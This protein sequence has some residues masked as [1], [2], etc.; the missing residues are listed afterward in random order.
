MKYVCELYVSKISL[1]TL[2]RCAAFCLQ[3]MI[4]GS[5]WLLTLLPICLASMSTFCDYA[6]SFVINNHPVEYISYQPN[7]IGHYVITG[8][9][10][11]GFAD[12]VCVES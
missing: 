10:I 11:P 5:K 12:L 8:N 3:N 4:Q 7:D 2:S 9:L 1:G 6:L